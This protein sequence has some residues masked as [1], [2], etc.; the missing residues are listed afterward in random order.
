[1]ALGRTGTGLRIGAGAEGNAP[2]AHHLIATLAATN[3]VTG[4]EFI[5]EL[6]EPAAVALGLKRRGK[7]QNSRSFD[8]RA[9]LSLARRCR[10]EGKIGQAL[11][12]FGTQ[13]KC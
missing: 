13:S 12:K 1:M 5:A 7:L 8:Q 6:L 11:P 10:T 3:P 9:A 2:A 4:L